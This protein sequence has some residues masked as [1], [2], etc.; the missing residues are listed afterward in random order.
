MRYS[1]LFLLIIPQLLFGQKDP[2]KFGKVSDQEKKI[3]K[4]NLDPDANAIILCDFGEINFL[5]NSVEITRHK[6]VKILNQEGMNEANIVLPYYHKDNQERIYGIKAQ[7]INTNENEKLEKIKVK[8]SEIYT[9]DLNENWKQKR[10]TFPNVKPGTIIEYQY[11]KKTENAVSL[12]EWRFQNDL[13]TL[14]SQLDVLVGS[15]LDYKIVYNG[16]RL[17]NKYGS[18]NA[19]SWL[20]ENLPP[21]KDEPFCPNP[22]DYIESIRFQLAG[23]LRYSS[24]PSGGSEY[25]QLMTTWENLAKEMLDYPD[26]KR[27]LNRKKESKKLVSQI[28]DQEDSDLEKVRKIYYFIQQELDWNGQH[29]LFPEHKFSTIIEEKRGSSAEINLCL[30]RLLQSAGLNSNPLI[31]STKGNGLITKIYPLYNQ[32]NHILAQVEID[33]KDIIM[34]AISKFR[35]YDLLSKN[36][37][38]PSGFLLHKKDSRWIEI[39]LPK[40]T[41]T[42]I[43][44]NVKLTEKEMKSKTSYSFFGH[45]AVQFRRKFHQEKEEASFITKYLHNPNNENET[46]LDSFSIKFPNNLEKPFAVTC[47]FTTPLEDGLESDIIYLDPFIKKHMTKNPFI[48]PI[49]YL[50]VD[51]I[52]PKKEKILYNLT[53]PEG[54]ELAETPTSMKFSTDSKK[55]SYTYAFSKSGEKNIQL[56]SNYQ[57]II[58]L[59][60][61]EEYGDLREL[62]NKIMGYQSNQIILKKK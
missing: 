15:N 31:I 7:T 36:D 19:N 5:G 2:I 26:F 56:S 43:V 6:R 11:T 40:K 32:F 45:D 12:E 27:V 57:I 9:V 23:Y 14:K 51:F 62:Y 48:N 18:K 46:V 21:L 8:K 3:Q 34:D 59:I 10:F 58:P 61:P 60:Y 1:I 13:P 22:D 37:L 41:R 39:D 16:S 38:K 30:V 50:P 29:R 44:N 35:P 33:G 28:I 4:T 24:L 47:Y 53:I 25:V 17:I 20:L 42:V 55:I 52:L 54:Y 49:R